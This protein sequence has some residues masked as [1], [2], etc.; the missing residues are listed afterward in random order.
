M[1]AL[2]HQCLGFSESSE[3][4]IW[5][6]DPETIAGLQDL[7]HIV[8]DDKCADYLRN[9]KMSEEHVANVGNGDIGNAAEYLV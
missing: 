3:D 1:F 8:Y 6:G 5:N 7:D 9:G 2:V 4:D